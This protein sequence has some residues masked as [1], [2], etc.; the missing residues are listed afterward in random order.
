[1]KKRILA[2]D[3]KALIAAVGEVLRHGLMSPLWLTAAY[4]GRAAMVHNLTAD[5]WDDLF[6]PLWGKNTRREVERKRGKR[7]FLVGSAVLEWRAQAPRKPIKE[8]LPELVKRFK[9]HPFFATGR[10]PEGVKLKAIEEAWAV[11]R[12]ELQEIGWKTRK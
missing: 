4:S 12:G 7:A 1:V 6:G 2:G 8:I 5:T 3:G 9:Y 10:K 11:F